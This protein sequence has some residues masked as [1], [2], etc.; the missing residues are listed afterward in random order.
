M[1]LSLGGWITFLHLGLHLG[2][3][4]GL[5]L[6]MHHLQVTPRKNVCGKHGCFQEINSITENE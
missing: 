2:L 6:P 5:Y 3:Y 4:P 1:D